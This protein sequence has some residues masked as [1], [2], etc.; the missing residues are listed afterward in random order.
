MSDGRRRRLHDLH[1]DATA[2]QTAIDLTTT[3]LSAA[4]GGAPFAVAA[5]PAKG[6][7]VLAL[8]DL[9]VGE[10]LL[11]ETPLLV[12]PLDAA[13]RDAK[14]DSRQ[15]TG[16][17]AFELADAVAAMPDDRR[18]R[19]F[20]LSQSD[21][22]GAEKTPEGIVQTNGIPFRSQHGLLGAVYSTASRFNHAC[23]ANAAFKFN[24]SLG[25]LTV[26]AV[27][28]I[29]AGTEITFNY[30][31]FLARRT[32][33]QRRLRDAFGFDCSCAKCQLSGSLLQRSEERLAALG[34]A[35]TL[36]SWLR[37]EGAL[38]AL[39]HSQPSAVLE[40]L[41]ARYALVE[42]EC[43]GAILPGTT[44]VVVRLCCDFCASAASRLARLQ[45]TAAAD[46]SALPK[47]VPLESL[48]G[49][50]A[51]YAKGSRTWASVGREI[52]LV[53]A[54]LDSQVYASYDDLLRA[55]PLQHE[56]GTATGNRHMSTHILYC[57]ARDERREPDPY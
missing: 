38:R 49:R 15:S 56:L 28:P 27:R 50:A 37:S 20:E 57:R 25:Q 14:A 40:E 55:P 43:S 3:R 18:R 42:A 12:V 53:M 32:Q 26:H 44:D 9:H 22:Y 39:I 48:A 36:T 1:R 16:I 13:G 23:D 51:A 46:A 19:F 41:A 17:S 7:G 6:L 47:D 8:R 30:G 34:D 11:A 24:S 10:R 2:L 52:A 21:C 29:S 33:R 31:G 35:A 4:T 45:S 54:G 5:L